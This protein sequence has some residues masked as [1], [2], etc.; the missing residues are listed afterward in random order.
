MPNFR[1]TEHSDCSS[2]QTKLLRKR[3][4]R[5]VGLS[6]SEPAG[7]FP[8]T[9]ARRVSIVYVCS[10]ACPKGTQLPHPAL[11]GYAISALSRFVN[12]RRLFS[13]ACAII[14][15][16]RARAVARLKRTPPM[17]T[18]ADA[19]APRGSFL[20]SDLSRF[21]DPSTQ[22]QRGFPPP[23]EHERGGQV[24]VDGINPRLHA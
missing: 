4:I 1:L 18:S 7:G 9:G 22:P 8:P 10:S 3:E 12:A 21:A 13:L 23:P 14:L 6:S 2:L 24:D 17:R 15:E 19:W 16:P 5:G 11:Q 20:V